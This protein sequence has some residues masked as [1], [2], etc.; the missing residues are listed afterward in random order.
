MTLNWLHTNSFSFPLRAIAMV[1]VFSVSAVTPTI[2]HH[3]PIQKAAH[4]RCTSLAPI[5]P[6]T[7]IHPAVY[8]VQ[9]NRITLQVCHH[10]YLDETCQIIAV[11]GKFYYIC[12]CLTSIFAD[13]IWNIFQPHRRQQADTRSDQIY[14]RNQHDRNHGRGCQDRRCCRNDESFPVYRLYHRQG[15]GETDRGDGERTSPHVEIRNFGQQEIMVQCWRIQETAERSG[16]DGNLSSREG[17][18]EYLC[19]VERIQLEAEQ[20]A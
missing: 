17:A 18:R 13:R 10:I 3:L 12:N 1:P 19:I 14:L 15:N 9:N 6:L 2:G 5:S 16:R 8:M 4:T 11:I 7:S 20:N